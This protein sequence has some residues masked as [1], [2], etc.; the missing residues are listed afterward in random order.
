ML[1]ATP[2]PKSKAS[3]LPVIY[4]TGT[5]ALCSALVHHIKPVIGM[6]EQNDYTIAQSPPLFHRYNADLANRDPNDSESN[7][8]ERDLTLYHLEQLVGPLAKNVI[9]MQRELENPNV[10]PPHPT[11]EQERQLDEIR[12]ELLKA[13]AAQAV[14]LD[15]VSGYVNTQQLAEVQHEGTEGANINAITGTELGPGATAAPTTPN[16]LLVDPSQVAGLA[17]NPYSMDPLSVPGIAGS[18]GNTPVTRLLDAIQ[19]IRGETERREDV[20]AE[21]IIQAA[22]AC[23]AAAATPTPHH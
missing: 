19:W 10:F 7:R 22:K 23:R 15:L 18:V 12:D 6:M 9:A 20:A 3:P 5:N 16:P 17:P 2:K 13:L 8:A 4:H 14:T 21:P 11:T 1:G